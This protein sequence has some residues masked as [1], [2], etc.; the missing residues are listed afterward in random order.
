MDVDMQA[1]LPPPG[2]GPIAP[3]QG[4]TFQCQEMH[5]TP[6]LASRALVYM[7]RTTPSPH[8]FYRTNIHHWDRARSPH[9]TCP[10]LA[11]SA[12]R[13]L[14]LR[15]RP[16]ARPSSPASLDPRPLP[17]L[18]NAMRSNTRVPTITPPPRNAYR[19]PSSRFRLQAEAHPDAH[20]TTNSKSKSPLHHRRRSRT[21][22]LACTDRVVVLHPSRSHPAR[23]GV[24][25]LRAGLGLG[26]VCVDTH[27][28]D[29]FASTTALDS[30]AYAALWLASYHV[31][32]PSR[33]ALASPHGPIS[34]P[35][36]QSVLFLNW[37]CIDP[38]Y[39]HDLQ[40]CVSMRAEAH[41]GVVDPSLATK[42]HEDALA[43]A[44]LR[45][46][47]A[48]ELGDYGLTLL[49]HYRMA[50]GESESGGGGGSIARTTG[51]SHGAT[52][53]T[54]ASRGWAEEREWASTA[55][56][57]SCYA[58]SS[59]DPHQ[60]FLRPPT[61]IES[62]SRFDLPGGSSIPGISVTP[63]SSETYLNQACRRKSCNPRSSSAAFKSMPALPTTLEA[64]MLLL[65]ACQRP[66]RTTTPL[67]SMSGMKAVA[68]WRGRVQ[69]TDGRESYHPSSSAAQQLLD[70]VASSAFRQI[71]TNSIK[72][73][74][75]SDH[76]DSD[77]PGISRYAVCLGR[78][79]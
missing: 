60:H 59:S 45:E 43:G 29:P 12:A 5:T 47:S 27:L 25:L 30:L 3:P 23:R 50:A 35:R 13:M 11:V 14:H 75:M 61:T 62:F 56:R 7:P 41:P 31:I 21:R 6:K 73:P 4:T 2:F 28:L 15:P 49:A 76:A 52:S 38:D 54:S 34:D 63:P 32:L 67:Y 78:L 71:H 10:P 55:A 57:S 40:E 19:P 1:H 48:P 37:H 46:F 65:L 72:A 70:A 68:H 9:P 74:S 77:C 33:P 64:V 39:T 58:V 69:A 17:R 16:L 36:Y 22:C 20:R 24:R 42:L 26:S 51:S 79:Q 18:P 66:R 44:N 8:I 53:S